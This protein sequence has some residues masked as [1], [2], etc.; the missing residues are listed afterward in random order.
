[1]AI[2]L[3]FI[4][5]RRFGT[6]HRCETMHLHHDK[7]L[8]N[9][10]QQCHVALEKHPWIGEDLEALLA[11]RI[12]P[13][14]W[15]PS[16]RLLTM[17]VDNSWTTLFSGNWWLLRKQPISRTC[18]SNRC[19]ICGSFERIPTAFTAAA[20]TR[21]GSGWAWLVVNKE[22]NL[23]T[24][25]AN[26][27]TPIQLQKPTGLG[28]LGTC[29]HVKYRNVR[30]GLSYQ[31]FSVITGTESRWI[32]MQQLNNDSWVEELFFFKVILFLSDKTVVDFFHFYEKRANC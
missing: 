21:F 28:R 6:I 4:C 23:A 8:S 2:I 27:D 29:L 12:Y 25:T 7:Q 19:N 11:D 31:S 13:G 10:C 1:M 30:P 18:S 14:S 24:S 9:L 5:I 15:Y 26:Q 32:A 22:V 3:I 16:W 20:T 17:V